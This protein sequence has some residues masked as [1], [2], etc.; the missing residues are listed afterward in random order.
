MKEKIL[1][2]I[3]IYNDSESV[4]L[5]IKN[6]SSILADH[7]NYSLLIVN[8]GSTQPVSV[9]RPATV[10]TTMLNLQRNIGHQKAISIGLAYAKNRN[11][12]EKIVIMDG[13]GQDNPEDVLRLIDVSAA[14][15]DTII[16][17]RRKS[18]QDNVQFKLFYK[19]YKLL[20]SLL[21][22]KKISFGNFLIM[23]K[24]SL[25]KIVFYSEIWNHLSGGIVKSGLPYTTIE[26][27]RN[28]R[29][30]NHSKMSFNSLVLHGLG[31]VSVFLDVIAIRLLVF[32]FIMILISLVII[33]VIIC[34]KLFTSLAIPGWA[35]SVVSSFVIILLQSFLLSLFTIF[36]YLTSQSQ[37]KFI[38]A[39][40]FTDYAG[41][42]EDIA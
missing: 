41:S 6:I 36:L 28:K 10:K 22:G 20:F 15:P 23:P 38:P 24:S 29:Y 31:A 13:D 9:Q 8:D 3:P 14:S 12:T 42:I 37:R 19:I 33:A 5:L 27:K 32:S 18:R 35:S 16:F 21:T 25:D 1:I 30:F 7:C 11:E 17:A 26:T 39:L 4:N 2:L 40:H 34:I